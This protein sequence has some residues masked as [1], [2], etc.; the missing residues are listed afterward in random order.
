[1]KNPFKGKSIWFIT[2]SQHLYGDET[3]RQA[4][5]DA[6]KIA[7]GLDASASVPVHV[8]CKGIVTR[9]EEILKVVREANLDDSCVG[10][11]L[12]MHTFSPAKMWI[13]GL[14]EMVKP[15]VHFHTQFYREI[16]WDSI[17]MDYMNLHQSAHGGREFGHIVSRMRKNRHVIAGHWEDE[18]VQ[19]E[20]G[21]WA[22]VAVGYTEAK[23]MK[24][25][26]FGDNM[27]TVAV[28]D[29]DKVTAQQKFG[30]VVD[31]YGIMDLV[32][33]MN[34]VSEAEIDRVIAEYEELY[35]IEPACAKGGAKHDTLREEAKVE[36]AL[37]SFLD[38]GGY[39]AFTTTFEDLHGM[40]QLP[41]LAVQRLMA[42]G[43]GFGGEGDW[44]TSAMTHILKV[45][46]YGT[47]KGTSFM[48]DY[49]YHFSADG[50]KV[51]GAHMLEVC[52]SIAEGGVKISVQP[53]GIGGKEDP[54]RMIFSA[55]EGEA[56]NASLIDIGDRFRLVV[57][58]VVSVKADAA[59]PK[60]PV[61]S[62]LW[63]PKPNLSVGAAAWIYTGAAHHSV[64]SQSVSSAQLDML[65]SMWDIEMVL[66]N[67]ETTLRG[68]QQELRWNDVTFS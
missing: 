44:K 65:S 39:T 35:E 59:L 36:V 6:Q 27:R 43:Y 21:Q 20:F 5:A 50:D 1:M 38:E 47:G 13:A 34:K 30:I 2:G 66:I 42:D 7:D 29:G 52:P 11:A 62:V 48:E 63:Q 3:L 37:R 53:L 68:I 22:R 67:D 31:G 19:A 24:V 41:G 61:A 58:E 16:P 51:L 18:A 56:L 49:T 26:R 33:V 14:Q 54:A 40:K 64:Y 32:D 57:N 46:G 25:A 23:T 55:A 45:I 10:I 60:L 9:S 12:W 17:D 28:T 15:F 8:M 4:A